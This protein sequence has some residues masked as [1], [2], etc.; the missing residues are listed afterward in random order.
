M[1]SKAYS[2]VA[3]GASSLKSKIAGEDGYESDKDGYKGESHLCRI[4]KE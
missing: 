3:L 4:M 1:W 2:A